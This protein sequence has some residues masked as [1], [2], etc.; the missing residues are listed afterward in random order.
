MPE[1]NTYGRHVDAAKLQTKCVA[2]LVTSLLFHQCTLLT[3]IDVPKLPPMPPTFV[4]LS[5]QIE[6]KHDAFLEQI[7]PIPT[8]TPQFRGAGEAEGAIEMLDG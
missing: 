1:R 8:F 5:R 3:I 7:K 2:N 4:F 6:K